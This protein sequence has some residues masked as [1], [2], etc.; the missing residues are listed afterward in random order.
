[1]QILYTLHYIM[2]TYYIYSCPNY[3][4]W[5]FLGKKSPSNSKINV[6]RAPP[7]H[8]IVDHWQKS[9]LKPPSQGNNNSELHRMSCLRF[10]LNGNLVAAFLISLGDHSTFAPIYRMDLKPYCRLFLWFWNTLD[11]LVKYS[12]MYEFKAVKPWKQ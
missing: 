10:F 1:M 4:D 8:E 2:D 11:C 7:G 6:R 12:W 5:N 3:I 9:V